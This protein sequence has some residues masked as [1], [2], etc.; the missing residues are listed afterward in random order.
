VIRPDSARLPGDPVSL[1][2]HNNGPPLDPGQRGRAHAWRVARR[3]LAPRLPLEVVRRRV[4]RARELGLAYP[5]YAS[6]LLGTGR[7]V[8]AFLVTHDAL[9]ARARAEIGM[10]EQRKARLEAVRRCHRVLASP[11]PAG[12]AFPFDAVIAAPREG[13][14]P[15]IGGAVL[16]AGLDPMRLPG[17]AVVMIGARADQREWAEAARLARFIAADAFFQSE[18]PAR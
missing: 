3:A 16:R 12:P 17:D 11:D 6:I 13:A 9:M 15:R 18:T 10:A 1:I 2:G 4:A 8:V 5:V 14:A 7:D